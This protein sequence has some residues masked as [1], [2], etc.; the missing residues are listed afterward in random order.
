[1]ASGEKVTERKKRKR[2]R[3][4]YHI[5]PSAD[6]EQAVVNVLRS[7]PAVSSQEKMLWLVNHELKEKDSLY[8]ITGPRLRRIAIR[9]GRVMIETFC[10][11][12]KYR[13]SVLQCP[14]CTSATKVVK[15]QTIYGGTVA[16]A[17]QCPACGYWS[18]LKFR[19]PVRYRFL[20]KE[21]D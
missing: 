21:G 17:H 14:V 12:T 19:M 9:T 3:G 1:M 4:H 5:P 7:N 20:L 6:V 13:R 2:V 16:L 10:R 15:N 18:G 8:V 11:E